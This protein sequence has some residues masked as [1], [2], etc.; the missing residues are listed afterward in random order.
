MAAFNLAYPFLERGKRRVGE[1]RAG[2]RAECFGLPLAQSELGI[3][4]GFTSPHI[5]DFQH[6]SLAR[7]VPSG[8]RTTKLTELNLIF[9]QCLQM[10]ETVNRALQDLTKMTER[11]HKI[12]PNHY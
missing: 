2:W 9:R 11:T 6:N 7:I 4:R 12:R 5:R 8:Y 10:E 3:C 1:Q